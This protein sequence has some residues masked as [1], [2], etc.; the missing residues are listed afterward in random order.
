M[1]HLLLNF[2]TLVSWLQKGGFLVALCTQLVAF[3]EE[4]PRPRVVHVL[5]SW[6]AKIVEKPSIQPL[7]TITAEMLQMPLEWLGYECHY[8]PSTTAK[9]PPLSVKNSAAVL[10]DGELN[11]REVDQQRIAQWLISAKKAGVPL[12]FVGGFAFTE[13]E[14]QQLL[15]DEL[16]LSGSLETVKDVQQVTVLKEP[17]GIFKG[18]T[19]LAPNCQ[20]FRDFQAPDGAAVLAELATTVEDQEL[21]FQPVFFASWGACWLEPCLIQRAS[22]DHFLF[23]VEPYEFFSRVLN[24]HGP[25]PAPD[26]TTLDGKRIFYS[27]IDGDGFASMSQFK[28][29]PLCA[30]IVRDRILKVYPYPVTVSVIE[31]EIS[32]DA[33]T[34]RDEDVPKLKAISREIFALPHVQAASHSYAHP[35]QWDV[36]DSNPGIY[37]APC[38]KLKPKVAYKPVNLEREI[39]GS[40]D[41]I[42][43]ELLPA[44]KKVEI[45]LWSGNTRPGVKALSILKQMGM[46]NMNG[47][48][49]IISHLYPGIAG[50]APRSIQWAD[51]E[52]Q[53]HAANQNEFMYAN[54]WQG[55]FYGGFAEV[56]DTFERTELPRRLKPVNVYYHFY[57]A[58]NLSS[59]RALEKIH[60]WCMTQ[61]LRP[62]TAHQF[63]RIVRDAHRTTISQKGPRHWVMN[64]QGDCRT[65]RL[66]N[67]L[68]EPD[69]KNS[70]GITGWVE[71]AGSLYI[72]TN[73]QPR[74]ELVMV[75]A[76]A[77]P[78]PESQAHLRLISSNAKIAFHSTTAQRVEFDFASA[79]PGQIEFAGIPA[80]QECSLSVDGDS[81]KV[82]AD[83]K[84]H[85]TLNLP[86]SGHVVLNSNISRYASLK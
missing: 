48:N 41:Y 57:S 15:R 27:H 82:Q 20:E 75:D 39:K 44:D 30:E 12:I 85:V 77:E 40:V 80:F 60:R 79:L 66:P 73:G 86:S 84:G 23:F 35:Y 58:T 25:L 59:T 1:A 53:I 67:N 4:T 70:S 19:K 10:L 38:M 63:A 64:N 42:N 11:I 13:P 24:V 14:S 78:L 45:F 18:E 22:Q 26:S 6:D 47:G 17:Q 34:T 74:T 50:V 71:H 69:L 31:A 62:I 33:L 81:Q 29:H 28:G 46:E 5:Y 68:G 61:P 51:G 3:G 56:V 55:P 9:L 54:G 83:A 2:D 32:G 21:H 52:L 43:R 49:T 37:D 36:T 7:D 8:V 76:K 72:H 65:F 16:G